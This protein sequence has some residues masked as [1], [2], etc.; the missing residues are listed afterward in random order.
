MVQFIKNSAYHS[1][2]KRSLCEAM[3]SCPTKAELSSLITQS[4]LHPIKTDE[5][6]EKF[7]DSQMI[8]FRGSQ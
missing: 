5:D 8:V 4:V 1:A 6:L 3:W 7:E 2:I